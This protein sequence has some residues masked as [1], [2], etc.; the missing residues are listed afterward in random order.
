MVD[1]REQSQLALTVVAD[2]RPGT[3]A[4][5]T[6]V[7]KE[8]GA[9]ITYVDI[10]DRTDG[11]ARI[12]FE[13]EEVANQA[14][15]VAALGDLGEVR[16]VI[17]E[18]TMQKIFGR[19]I[20]VIGAGAQVSS[21]VSGAVSEADRHNIRGER[22]SVDTIP[23]VGEHEI[24]EAVRATGRLPRVEAVVL[25]GSLM[26]GEISDAVRE[27]KARGITVVTLN[28]AGSVRKEAD[29]VVSDPLQA[30]VMAVMLVAK[31]ASLDIDRI[32]GGRF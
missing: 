24:A 18:A 11:G 5:L 31:T 6:R 25:A 26:G 17:A 20:I 1:E 28:M 13:F 32:R 10:F 15:L 30:G 4:N 8:H 3:L 7:I 12:L 29:L 22:I 14:A 2:D 19:R 16:E 21:V 9:N 27:V 23:L